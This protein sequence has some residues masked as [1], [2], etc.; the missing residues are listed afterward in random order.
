MFLGFVSSVSSANEST[1]EM[2]SPI[3]IYIF[4][5]L[6]IY[7]YHIY[8]Y[9]L[10]RFLFLGLV[11]SITSANESTPEM[12][13]PPK[14]TKLSVRKLGHMP[15]TPVA[16]TGDYILI[17]KHV[18]RSISVHV[19]IYMHTYTCI[20]IYTYIYALAAKTD[21]TQR[22]QSWPHASDALRGTM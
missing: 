11:S 8:T 1:P 20:Y 5:Y 19:Y 9:R 18:D 2:R 14:S 7:L 4:I 22:A 15:V 10:T 3:Y 17:N 16:E 6:S 21:E 12:N 13:S